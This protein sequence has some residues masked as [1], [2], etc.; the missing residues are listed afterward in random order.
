VRT[1]MRIVADA[2]DV[3]DHP[4]IDRAEAVVRQRNIRMNQRKSRRCQQNIRRHR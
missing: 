2:S 1:T 3:L 4:L